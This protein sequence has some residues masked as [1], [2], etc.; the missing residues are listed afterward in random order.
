MLEYATPVARAGLAFLIVVILADPSMAQQRFEFSA[1]LA[2]VEVY[3]DNLFFHTEAPEP[4]NIWRLSP[5]LS[6]GRRSPRLTLVGRYGLDAESYRRHPSLDT[7]LAGQ[8]ASLEMS[9]VPSK[10]WTA[11]TIASYAEAQSPGALN[12]LTGLEL[13]R[14]RGRRLSA[15]ESLSWRI[16]ART[17][18]VLE[19]S[20]TRE[21]VAG[22]P[23]T[24]T[25]T[26]SLRLERR[27]GA[28]DV[29]HIGY[30]ARRFASEADA[31]LS[32]VVTLGWRREI[33]PRAH[34]ELEAGP[35]LSEH[36]VGAE[37]TASLRHRFARGEA[38][39]SYIHTQTT[40]LGQTGP[41]MTQGVT[42]TFRTQMLQSLTLA[43]G[44]AFARV[45]GRGSEFEIYRLDVEVAWRLTR[46]LSL[47]AS[48]QFTLQRG[49]PG[50][51][52]PDAEIVHNA[53]MLRAVAASSRN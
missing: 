32:H 43:A 31:I 13:G 34:F 42:A 44:P 14:R 4:D 27:L 46:R 52:R 8:D 17:K 16:G 25:Q 26:A 50:L 23:R 18:G 3:D 28:L 9:W 22:L 51:A 21:E 35:R 53:L 38:G 6:L 39:L 19:Q 40:V 20:S 48:H 1:S 7:P 24:D 12:V 37:V 2:A 10:R 30:S 5:R 36:V 15:R 41:V 11:T 29:G 47:S 33:T 45:Q 49:V